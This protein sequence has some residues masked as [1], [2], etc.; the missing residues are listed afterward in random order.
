MNEHPKCHIASAPLK[1]K[2][3]CSPNHIIRYKHHK[4]SSSR[5]LNHILMEAV[6]EISPKIK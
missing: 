5:F 6:I 1:M 4:L 3:A 2:A